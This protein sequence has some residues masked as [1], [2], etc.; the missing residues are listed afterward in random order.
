MIFRSVFE[1]VRFKEK[2]R[3]VFAMADRHRLII[4]NRTRITVTDVGEVYSFDETVVNLRLNDDTDLVISGDGLVITKLEVQQNP[5][6]DGGNPN[7]AGG[8]V[9]IN[10]K[11]EAVVY[12]EPNRRTKK[13]DGM[14]SGSLFGIFR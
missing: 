8:E 3:E 6:I 2:D 11:V 1:K 7:W 14:K 13:E 9:I 4:E 12:S 10:G 5:E